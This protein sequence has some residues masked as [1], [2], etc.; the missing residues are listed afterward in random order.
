MLN[1]IIAYFDLQSEKR[2][3]GPTGFSDDGS[4]HAPVLPQYFALTLGVLVDPLLRNY[5]ASGAFNVS[6]QTLGARSIFALLIA[7]VLL[8]AVYRN[9]FDPSRPISVQL[10]ALF[11]SGLGWQSVFQAAVKTVAQ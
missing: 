4:G 3:R 2:A 9:A 11:V 1:N 5:I 8:P 6:F 10:C 7:I